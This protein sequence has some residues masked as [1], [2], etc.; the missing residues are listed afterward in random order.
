MGLHEGGGD[1][2]K[3]REVLRICAQNGGCFGDVLHRM[4]LAE[5]LHGVRH[6]SRRHTAELPDDEPENRGGLG[7]RLSEGPLP[8]DSVREHGGAL[9][10]GERGRDGEAEHSIG[11]VSG[12]VRADGD[13]AGRAEASL[14]P[15]TNRPGSLS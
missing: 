9:V 4:S 13:P 12:Q 7:E 6:R 5:R 15:R 2:V 3:N 1:G 11:R 14:R 8:P 10:G